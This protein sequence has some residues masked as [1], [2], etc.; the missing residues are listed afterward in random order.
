MNNKVIYNNLKKEELDLIKLGKNLGIQ[1][2]INENF[3]IGD[4]IPTY[5]NNINY[6]N[7]LEKLS[8][9]IRDK[10]LTQSF[11]KSKDLF[12]SPN[13]SKNINND[14]Y[15]KIPYK[16]ERC[17]E[18]TIIEDRLNRNIKNWSSKSVVFSSCMIGLNILLNVIKC[19]EVED[20][21]ISLA[22]Y[23]AYFETCLQLKT[24]NKN[25]FNVDFIDDFE[26]LSEKDYLNNLDVLLFEPVKYDL[27]LQPINLNPLIENIKNKEKEKILFIIVDTTLHDYN[28]NFDK[29]INNF[30]GINNL[31]VVNLK[32][33]LKLSQQGLEFARAGL[34]S[35][36]ANKNNEKA[37]LIL[38]K[39]MKDYRSFMGGSLS[40]QDLCLLDFDLFDKDRTY[41]NEVIKNN[42]LFA[43]KLNKST[44]GVIDKVIHTSINKD[45]LTDSPF[46]FIK[47]KENTKENY[48]IILNYLS[49]VL[50]K[51]NLNPEIGNSYG[52]R[53]CRYELI[54]FFDKE[55]QY[56][57][58]ISLG[59][60]RGNK[61][62]LL[63]NALI[64]LTKFDSIKELSQ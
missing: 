25:G 10:W 43:L 14:L 46:L 54:K 64:A 28:F 31:F 2:D 49:D 52:F 6:E 61:Y 41:V 53:N 36:Y 9:N 19:I 8:Y 55:S 37:L 12:K 34:V 16:Y 5:E 62:Y 21:R 17:L 56:I 58:K 38:P 50:I 15:N 26:K 22:Y 59:K 44:G 3:N 30:I 60:I 40:F 11:Q 24:F 48:N 7:Y 33:L 13:I 27:S 63:L 51:N 35:I 32:S 42:K 23:G 45:L 47:L 18:P 57:L 20:R 4:K 29:F 1:I 39:L